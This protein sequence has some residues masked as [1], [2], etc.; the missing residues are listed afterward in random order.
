MAESGVDGNFQ[1]LEEE[2]NRLLEVLEQFRS[3]NSTLRERTAALES[4]RQEVDRLRTRLAQLEEEQRQTAERNQL[5]KGRL[6]QI[7]SRLEAAD[8]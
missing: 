1:R 2:V 5:V 3:E 4:G 8:L 6:G 7:L